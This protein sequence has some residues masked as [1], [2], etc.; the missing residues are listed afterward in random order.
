[1]RSIQSTAIILISLLLILSSWTSG[2]AGS[3][4]SNQSTPGTPDDGTFSDPAEGITLGLDLDEEIPVDS[5]I[6]VVG[7]P[8]LVTGVD[9]GNA[10]EFDAAGEYL[11]VPDDA[12]NDLTG[13]SAAI[14]LW[15]MP[16]VNKTGAGILHKGTA[17]DWSDESYSLQY[18]IPGEL[19]FIITN[20]EDTHTYVISKAPKLAVDTWYHIVVTWD[21][22]Q[23]MIYVNGVDVEKKYIQYKNS[24]WTAWTTTLPEDFA[25][26]RSS[27]GDLMIGTQLPDSQPEYRFEGVIDKIRLYDRLLSADEVL[28]HYSEEDV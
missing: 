15:I 28:E 26:M 21:Q 6:Q 25:P 17:S 22:T 7:S 9:G 4:S 18:N 3:S 10:Y 24:A 27:D 13:E 5:P 23:V 12:S 14:E 8:T 19:A 16:K 1:M 11:R 20:Q 2:G